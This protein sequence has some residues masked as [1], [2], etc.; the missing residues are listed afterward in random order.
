MTAVATKPRS[1][2]PPGYTFPPWHQSSVGTLLRCGRWFYLERV[3]KVRPDHGMTG[4]A[5]P[6]GTAAHTVV[7]QILRASN[8]GKTVPVEELG[9]R[10]SI[11]FLAA[12]DEAVAEG[13]ELDP[14]ALETALKK[15]DAVERR[16]ELFAVDPRIRA[17]Y[18]THIEHPFKWTDR[19]GRVF[20][21][22]MDG[23]GTATEDYRNWGMAGRDPV[24]LRKGDRV[25]CDWKNGDVLHLS[26]A[27]RR[28]N[29]Q[30][31]FYALALRKS[32]KASATRLPEPSCFIGALRD[33]D[34]TSLPKDE[35]GDSIPKNLNALNPAFVEAL[36][37]TV[38]EAEQSRKGPKDSDG[39]RI[40]KRLK[41][42]NPAWE[43]A[44]NKPRGPMLRLCEVNH[45]VALRTVA[46]AITGAEHGLFPAQGALTGAC[47][48]CPFQRSCGMSNPA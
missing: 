48:F 14:D 9:E 32:L 5:A 3:L 31:A 45:N 10:L 35:N 8:R 47:T 20:R 22:T 30:L 42:I 39:N 19:S 37:V 36:G 29:V 46:D 43:V 1:A 26:R 17:V 40:P 18:W 24:H 25:L 11:A 12:L 23:A 38:E 4:Y 27:A 13:A 44:C 33:L 7:E 6:I 34:R 21:G 2:L 16:L 41:G 28:V 15:V